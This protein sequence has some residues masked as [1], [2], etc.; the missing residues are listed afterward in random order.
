MA[1]IASSPAP[2]L[3]ER[4]LLLISIS[5]F[6]FNLASSI[7]PHL[8]IFS[9]NSNNSQTA[10]QKGKKML[11]SLKGIGSSKGIGAGTLQPPPPQ[12]TPL[13]LFLV[14]VSCRVA[15]HRRACRAQAETSSRSTSCVSC[16]ADNGTRSPPKTRSPR[17]SSYR[18]TYGCVRVPSDTR[19]AHS[20]TRVLLSTRVVCV[21]S[22]RVVSWAVC[23]R[24]VRGC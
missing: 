16:G 18:N 9:P 7:H 13:T 23:R 22:C 6:R 4:V 1:S 24:I 15:C 5:I 10:T 12:T 11:M 14:C 21:V 20:L 8:P 19:A 17:S 2:S 3:S